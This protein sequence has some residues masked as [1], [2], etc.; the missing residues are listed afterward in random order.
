MLQVMLR[1]RQFRDRAGRL[2]A[3]HAIERV[4]RHID[5]GRQLPLDFDDLGD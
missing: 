1:T 4:I 2:K 5:G 3:E